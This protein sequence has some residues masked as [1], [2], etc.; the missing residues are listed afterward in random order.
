M[1]GMWMLRFAARRI[2]YAVPLILG[3]V[4][5]NFLLIQLAP[6]DPVTVL[7]GDYPVPPEYLDQIRAQFG[8]DKPMLQQ[9]WIYFVQ[10]LHGNLG[11]SYSHHQ[12]VLSLIMDRIGAT[13]KLTIT[14]LVLATVVGILLGVIS[15]KFRGSALDTTTQTVSLIGFSV[16]EFWLGQLLIL[17]FAVKLGW[18]PASGSFSIREGDTG[19]FS[20]LNY[21]VLPV[22]ALSFRYI[23]IIARMTRANLLEVSGADFI[24][25]VRSRGVGES[26]VLWRHT[27][28]NAAPPVLTVVGY[29]FGYILAGSVT[30]ETVFSWPGIGRLMYESIGARDYP[31]LVGILLMI[32]VTIV[33]A[34][35]LTDLVH[36]MIDPRVVQGS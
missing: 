1:H 5:V 25:A 28:K 3:V 18:L 36:A 20:T 23:A 30:I 14:A 31:V 10:L 19:F 17:L 33:I 4:V 21:L 13:A 35:L 16:P 7:V 26:G 15:A 6:G 22:I 2:A 29:N 24:T 9:L 12:T 27:M 34:N 32:S 11:M 8:L